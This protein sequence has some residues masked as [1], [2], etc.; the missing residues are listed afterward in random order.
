ML[1][2]KRVRRRPRATNKFIQYPK[3]IGGTM[4]KRLYRSGSDLYIRFG[5]KFHKV[6]DP[7]MYPKNII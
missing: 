1:R 6:F 7:T 5:K 2:I 4:M 3:V